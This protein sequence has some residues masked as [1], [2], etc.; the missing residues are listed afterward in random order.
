MTTVP[1]A[2]TRFDHGAPERRLELLRGTL[3]LDPE[4]AW[5]MRMACG[6]VVELLDRTAGETLQDRWATVEEE[7]WI[8]WDAGKD[9]RVP[10][11]QWTW[12]PAVLVLSRSVRLGWP[13]LSRARL[14][15]WLRWLP[16]EDRLT[17]ELEWLRDRIEG[18]GWAGAETRRRGSLL[19]LRVM[20]HHGYDSAR[21]IIE[22]DL[23]LVPEHVSRGIDA[24]DAMLSAEGVLTRTA[25]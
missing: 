18:I 8:A 17:V 9:R 19:G 21:K 24:L 14:S 23:R 10:V 2:D 11:R 25:G 16:P 20:L 22:Q 15:Q 7:H 12:G 1:F 13:L 5:A 6:S 4:K 3:S